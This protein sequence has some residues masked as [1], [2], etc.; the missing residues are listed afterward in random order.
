MAS[1]A[2]AAPGPDRHLTADGNPVLA[3]LVDLTNTIGYRFAAPWR[4]QAALT[5]PSSA[6]SDR[7]GDTLQNALE[8]ER[9]EFLGDRVLGLV[10]AEWLLERFPKEREGDL[11]KRHAGLVRREALE[12][13]AATLSLGR[14][15]TLSRG[16]ASS[17]GRRNRTILSD[18]CEA[19]IGALYLDGGL[20]VARRFIRRYW[21]GLIEG[22]TA[23]PRD[24]KTMLQEW[25]QGRGA[26]LPAYRVIRQSGPPHD[27]QFEVSVE[28][29]EHAPV[30][31]RGSSRRGAEKA[32]A[33][34][35]LRT[36]GVVCDD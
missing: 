22:T 21:V 24:A 15:L 5:H 26:P 8:Y 7:R 20:D 32:A 28:V 9:L 36:I 4:L 19:L 25:A 33:Q 16:E 31:G 18:A 11:A 6:G 17:G 10:V 27:P 13:V 1:D 23:P 12:Q 3:D 2:D 30:T 35:M 29:S 14:Y 34:A